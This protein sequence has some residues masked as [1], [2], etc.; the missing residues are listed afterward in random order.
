MLSSVNPSSSR[1]A[2][3]ALDS[4]HSGSRRKEQPSDTRYVR[5]Y[6]GDQAQVVDAGAFDSCAADLMALFRATTASRS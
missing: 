5:F 4:N 6:C 2:G 3:F 1:T